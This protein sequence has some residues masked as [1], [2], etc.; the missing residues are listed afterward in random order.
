MVKIKL[1][2]ILFPPGRGLNFYLFISVLECLGNDMRNT[3]ISKA[4]RLIGFKPN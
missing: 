3:K 2:S 4:D 1:L